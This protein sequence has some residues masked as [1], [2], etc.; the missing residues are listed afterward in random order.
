MSDIASKLNGVGTRLEARAQPLADSERRG[1]RRVG[2]HETGAA[3]TLLLLFLA[4]AT[5][6]ASPTDQELIGRALPAARAAKL[7]AQTNDAMR[8]HCLERA[9]TFSVPV[10]PLG[11]SENLNEVVIARDRRLTV[12]FLHLGSAY[13]G[14]D[15]KV[16]VELSRAGDVKKITSTIRP[17]RA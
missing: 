11:K 5:G 4:N 12:S 17:P 13:D 16:E 9:L 6:H 7:S 14:Y 2:P 1:A 3:M 10:P 8:K 15:C